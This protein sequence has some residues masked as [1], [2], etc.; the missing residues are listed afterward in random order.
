M[1]RP[2]KLRLTKDAVKFRK[3]LS[4][5]TKN[6][7]ALSGSLVT[8]NSATKVAFTKAWYVHTGKPL[9]ANVT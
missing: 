8:F 5:D 7:R 2:L 6:L 1:S 9:H 4:W 3:Q